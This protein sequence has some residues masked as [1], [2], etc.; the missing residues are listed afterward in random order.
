MKTKIKY[1]LCL[2]Y[3]TMYMK[4][5]YIEL[6]Y[7]CKILTIRYNANPIEHPFSGTTLLS[8][9]RIS[10]SHDLKN[11]YRNGYDYFRVSL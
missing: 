2:K 7:S 1:L 5:K 3:F 8:N 10:E 6:T 9:I 11:L 4:C